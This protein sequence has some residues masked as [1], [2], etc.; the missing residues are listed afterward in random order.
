MHLSCIFHALTK[1]CF[2][3]L[4][5][6]YIPLFRTTSRIDLIQLIL[7]E[8]EN[9]ASDCSSTVI[10]SAISKERTR[11]TAIVFAEDK[12]SGLIL[13]CDVI[14]DVISSLN[15]VTTTKEL[16][17][18][19]APEAFEVRAYDDQGTYSGKLH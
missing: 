11:N 16:Y 12:H 9:F 4:K 3:V 14:V 18:E 8:N 7:P 15:L 2:T 6:L 1:S 5:K 19:E 17:M 10:V 13:R